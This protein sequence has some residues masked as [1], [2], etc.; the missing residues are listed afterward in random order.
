MTLPPA[1]PT[2]LTTVPSAPAVSIG[3][4]EDELPALYHAQAWR[5]PLPVLMAALAV[6][7]LA[8]ERAPWWLTSGWVLAVAAVLALRHMVIRTAHLRLELPIRWRLNAVAA[9]SALGGIVHGS[10]VMF[11]PHLGDLG[12]AVQSM[13]VL[14]L[15]AGSIATAFGYQ[16]IVLAY[17]LP[18]LL[19]L[20]MSWALGLGAGLGLGA[21]GASAGVLLM[22]VL[23]GGL[24]TVLARD[25]FKL[26]RESFDARQRLQVA[27]DA[28]ES[29]N[30]AK[31][32]FLASASHDLRQPMHTLSLFSAALAMR[33]LDPRS[34]A[35]VSQMNVALQALSSQLDA[36]LDVS[37]LDAGVVVA[38]PVN[39][40]LDQML[41][42]LHGDYEPLAAR[43]GLALQ[44][45]SFTAAV[46]HSDPVLLE[47]V[48]RNL[49][50]NAIKYT[51]A[52]VVTVVA[53]KVVR[54]AAAG[55]ELTLRDSGPGIAGAEHERVFEEFYQLGNP[56]RDRRQGLGL[57]LS[58]VRRLAHLLELQ[59]QMVSAPGQG[60]QFTLQLAA[61]SAHLAAAAVPASALP[62]LQALDVL[63]L[64]DEEAVR[65]AMQALL[66]GLG[67]TVRMAAD[68]QS[69]LALARER[70]P[71]IV[72]ADLRLRGAEDG[73]LAVQA[74][75][76][77]QPGLAALL[78]S[79][80]T[81]P[82]RLRQVHA[83]GLTLL[84]KPVAMETLVRAIWNELQAATQSEAGD[85]AN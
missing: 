9:V 16:R 25:T 38:Q 27:L 46:V 83:S 80:D 31:T 39:F 47:R 54:G 12:R 59:L 19:P 68:T 40:S 65:A 8:F 6:A 5:V 66:E 32:R 43:K 7:A 34:Q 48:L 24:L 76:Q 1:L 20:G 58:I 11:W 26:F 81:P 50:D 78:I 42:R 17:L 82:E 2:K 67:C 57:G 70:T 60:T 15:C 84:H 13:F 3:G 77:L 23:Y 64:D 62:S 75:R 28:A 44:L 49:L 63:A 72:L 55:F 29:A 21:S 33:P 18:M 73:L 41:R 10:S 69:A 22:F 30:R 71:H 85:A 36:L 51:P 52:G 61:A 79:G 14:G 4:V 56:E 53:S 37:K 74:L 45:S 35:I